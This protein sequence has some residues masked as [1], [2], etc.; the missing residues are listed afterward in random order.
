[1]ILG[2][3]EVKTTLEAFIDPANIPKKYGGQLEF[4]FGQAPLLDPIIQQVLD[5][6]KPYEDFPPGPLLWEEQ[7]NCVNLI[8]VGTSEE[9]QRSAMIATLQKISGGRN[10]DVD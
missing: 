4:Q 5:W 2:E 10:S 6:H 1:M 9:K 7:E 8:A 3:H